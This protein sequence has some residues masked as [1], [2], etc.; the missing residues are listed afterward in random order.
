M[1]FL[2]HTLISGD[3]RQNI[4]D[5]FRLKRLFFKISARLQSTELVNNFF[6]FDFVGSTW[7]NVV[8]LFGVL[9]NYYAN[10][11]ITYSS[12]CVL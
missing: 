6:F 2:N 8:F 12:L 10:E 9:A 5:L 11:N 1:T 3:F 7:G 4:R